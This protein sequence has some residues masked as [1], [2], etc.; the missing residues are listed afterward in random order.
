M[1]STTTT[2]RSATGSVA[3]RGV[4][5]VYGQGESAV[6]ALDGVSLDVAPGEFVCL[7]GA[8]GCGKSTLLNLVAGLDRASGGRIELE[9]GV[10]PGLM[11]QEPALFPWLTVEG[12]V[13]MPLKLRGLP[14]AER[15]AR[16]AELLRT[17]HL[18]DFGRKRPHQLSGGMRQRVAL[19]RTLALDTPVLLMDEPFGALDAMTRD[20]LHDELERIWSERRLTVLFVTH[21]VREAARLA[22]RII[23]L[24]SRPGRIIWS[25]RVDVPRPRRI[26]SPEIATIA[27]EV[28]DRLR[29]EVGRHGQ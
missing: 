28:T 23:L 20:I 3:L 15:R 27:A 1:T 11:F 9:D 13:D 8:S 24:S 26:D 5:K 22:D 4:T 12:N 7:V 21:N 25:T 17:V 14:R 16:V 29:T 10:N 6:L 18:A 19:A 2:A